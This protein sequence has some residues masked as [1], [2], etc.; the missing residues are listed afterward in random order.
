VRR[1]PSPL[2]A[3]IALTSLPWLASCFAPRT[4]SVDYNAGSVALAKG[5][6]L[7]IG[8]GR[9]SPGI[10]DEWFLVSAPD[11]AVL[12][13]DGRDSPDCGQAGC[14]TTLAWLFSAA[15]A[16][17]T[18]LTLRYCYRSRPD[19]CDPGPGRGPVDPATLHVTVR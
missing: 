10:G 17:T 16:G 18:D 1:L 8:L 3:A 19:K 13:D 4:V 9:Y 2:I 12:H 7:R 11:P 6:R 5:E 15:G 14:T